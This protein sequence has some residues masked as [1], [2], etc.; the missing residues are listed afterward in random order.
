M[1]EVRGGSA[2]C[3]SVPTSGRKTQTVGTAPTDVTQ[4][5]ARIDDSGGSRPAMISPFVTHGS[6]LGPFFPSAAQ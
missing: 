1:S 2:C 3:I 4:S 6:W 5:I